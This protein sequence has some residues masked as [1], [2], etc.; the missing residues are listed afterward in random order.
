MLC[1]EKTCNY[2]GANQTRAE[3]RKAGRLCLAE[4]DEGV[5]LLRA[6]RAWWLGWF[7]NQPIT[8]LVCLQMGLCFRYNPYIH[9]WDSYHVQIKR[10]G[11]N[12]LNRDLETFLALLVSFSCG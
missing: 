9:L 11:T 1:G 10:Q 2:R 8:K 3:S 4:L 7:Q 5:S 12:G 6:R